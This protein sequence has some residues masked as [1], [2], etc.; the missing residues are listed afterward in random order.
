M[1][2]CWASTLDPDRWVRIPDVNVSI[3]APVMMNP[4]C[5]CKRLSDGGAEV[6]NALP[7]CRKP[8]WRSQCCEQTERLWRYL[9]AELES[10][11]VTAPLE[12]WN[13]TGERQARRA[14]QE[15]SE[16]ICSPLIRCSQMRA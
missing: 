10:S 5:K 13:T 8:A 4:Q 14:F 16:A 9:L 11:S 6:T 2:R 15:S 3:L 12:V 7:V 1:F